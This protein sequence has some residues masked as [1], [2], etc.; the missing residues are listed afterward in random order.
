MARR[1][2][3]VRLPAAI[4]AGVMLAITAP[5]LV[6]LA[7]AGG[8]GTANWDYL[9][10]AARFTLWQASLST[11]L[12]VGLALPVALCLSR[13][14]FRGKGFVLQLLAVPQS[15]PPI[16]AV[17]G[18][19][20]LLGNNGILPGLPSLYGLPGILIAHVFFNLPFA[21]R[22]FVAALE[23]VPGEHYRLAEALGMDGK[24]QWRIVE[25]PRLRQ[26]LPGVAGL[27][28]MLCVT[29]FTIILTLGGG[30]R[31]ATLEVA[32]YQ[33]LR[34]DYD[35]ALALRL[36][37]AQ[38]ALCLGIL[39]L[40]GIAT[41]GMAQGPSLGLAA[42]RRAAAPLWPVWLAVFLVAA[43]LCAVAAAGAR[44]DFA[45]LLVTP[46][47]WQ[48]LATSSLIA[49]ASAAFAV[50][51]A[52]PLAQ[53]VARQGQAYALLAKMPLLLPP[54][55]LGAGWFLLTLS[56]GA[57]LAPLFVVLGN[58]LIALPF[59]M[60]ALGP[61]LAASAQADDRLCASLGI[62]GF[63]RLAVI[64][65]PQLRRPLMLAMLMAVMISFG[66]LGIITFFGAEDFITLPYLLY[67][68]LGSYRSADAEGLALLLLA[69]ALLAGLAGERLGRR[70]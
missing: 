16:I 27:I 38:L 17:L 48:A 53:A 70:A 69:L 59:A 5:A 46:L 6:A 43:P 19:L 44:A 10:R 28:F 64:D 45:A 24:A 42:K 57:R 37:L 68:K 22:L 47:V 52:V 1:D 39:V 21:A 2:G 41:P 23:A 18:L 4:A 15:L 13:R 11:A 66:D 20:A 29:S 33:A 25:W 26:A 67:L 40:F 35:P 14:Q 3:Q 32:I 7:L 62:S 49:L 56:L 65:W 30:P 55:V 36:V 12:S 51:L 63:R 60:E 31:A 8:E 34:F 58:G 9:A 61:R 54:I 50:A